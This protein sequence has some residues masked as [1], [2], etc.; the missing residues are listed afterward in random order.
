MGL[1]FLNWLQ[2]CHKGKTVSMDMLTG[3]QTLFTVD[4]GLTGIVIMIKWLKGNPK[5]YINTN[6]PK[7]NGAWANSNDKGSAQ[8]EYPELFGRYLKLNKKVDQNSLQH[9]IFVKDFINDIAKS[10]EQFGKLRGYD[11]PSSYYQDL[12]WKGLERTSAFLK[13]WI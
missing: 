1:V 4:R 6:P 8:L 3:S 10:I 11:L 12:A 5:D 9:E 13:T 2:D 7:G